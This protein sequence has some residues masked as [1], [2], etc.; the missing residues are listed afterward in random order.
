MITG[1]ECF[2]NEQAGIGQMEGTHT[3]IVGNYVH[4]NKTSGIGFEAGQGGESQVI[5]NRV[6]DNA[7]VA[8]GVKAN[9]NVTFVG[10]HF[11]R[12]GGLPPIVMVQQSASTTFSNNVLRGGGVAGIR[13]AG[14]VVAIDKHFDGTSFRAVGPPN[15]AIWGL[16]GSHVTM[17]GNQINCWRHALSSNKG[18]AILTGNTVRHP[19]KAAFVVSDPEMNPLIT[20]NILIPSIESDVFA[21]VDGQ[22]I[23]DKGNTISHEDIVQE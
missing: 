1:N 7:K 14:N 18:Q 8:V 23:S 12:T 17:D 2:E 4:H 21:I 5:N 13:V 22:P 3:T 15:F 10:N 19:S 16:E 20:G 9:W 6:I 11:S